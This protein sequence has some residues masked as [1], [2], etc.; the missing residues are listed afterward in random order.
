V[1]HDDE[2]FMVGSLRGTQFLNAP[3]KGLSTSKVTIEV[4]IH[5]DQVTLLFREHQIVVVTH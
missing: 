1:F 5:L 4:T 3:M 2:D